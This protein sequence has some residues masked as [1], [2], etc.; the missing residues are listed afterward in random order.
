MM[1][2]GGVYLAG[3]FRNE[4]ALG[5]ADLVSAGRL[6]GFLARLGADGTPTWALRFR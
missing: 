6:D 3:A 2:D 1:A 5:A 4:L